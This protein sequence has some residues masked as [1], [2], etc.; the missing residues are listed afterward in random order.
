MELDVVI[1]AIG[2]QEALERDRVCHH[3]SDQGYY[4]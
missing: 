1:Q 4:G 3:I 2:G